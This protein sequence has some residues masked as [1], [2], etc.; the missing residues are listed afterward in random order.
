LYG[1]DKPLWHQ[2]LLWTGRMLRFDFGD[3]YKDRRPVLD[4]IGDALPITIQINLITIII[5]YTLSMPLGIFSA[6]QHGTARDKA[7]TIVLFLLYSL[8][9]FWVA[10]LL[11]FFLANDDY[12]S[13][14]PVYG[15]NSP[16]ADALP[17]Y[18]WLLD[19]LWHL[20]LPV[21]CLSYADFAYV[22]RFM[23]SDMIETIR[24]D[25]IRTARAYGFSE[26]T[27]AYKYALRNSLIS[28]ITLVA[29]L[30]PALLGG[31]VIIEQI[32]SIPGMGRLFFESILSRDYPTVMGITTITAVLTLIGLVVQDILYALAD[33]R[34]RYGKGS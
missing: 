7:T 32:F 19:R 11:I 16:Q 30:L 10:M 12:V 25:Y 6:Q 13:W 5:V 23:R 17:W 26:R 9:S 18:K 22:S 20:A 15:L 14:F 27:V 3:S 8:P 28:L 29:T 24:Q 34:I 31:S 21:F 2:Y 33:P 1:L 4:K